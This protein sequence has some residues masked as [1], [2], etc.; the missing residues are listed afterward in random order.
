[1]GALRNPS[2]PIPHDSLQYIVGK[3][4]DMPYIERGLATIF[5]NVFW[6][7]QNKLLQVSL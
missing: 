2:D 4:I 6:A 1:M 7:H 5:R 3:Y